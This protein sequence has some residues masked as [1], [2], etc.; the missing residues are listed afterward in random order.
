M[1]FGKHFVKYYFKY[2]IFFALGIGVLI[3]IDYVQLDIPRLLG[4]IINKLEIYSKF[5]NESM[6]DAT[7]NAITILVSNI[8]TIVVI[9]TVGRML[10]RLLI[11]GT[12]RRIEYDLRNVMF[13][14]ATNLSQDFYSHEKVGGMM[15]YFINDLAAIRMAFGP[16]ILTL[17]D[18][19]FLGGFAVYRMLGLNKTMTI[20][21]IV[22]M[23]FMIVAMYFI[24]TSMRKQFRIRQEKFR[25]LSDYTQ[26]NFSGISVIKAYVKEIVSLA[27]FRRKS[28]ELYEFNIKYVKRAA[29]SEI[30]TSIAIN[31]VIITIIAYGG[32]LVIHGGFSTG[33]LIEYVG[34]FTSLLWPTR[35]LARFLTISSQAQASS[36]RVAEF[37]DSEVLVKDSDDL[38]EV[39]EIEPSITFKNLNFA[40]PDDNT[41]VLENLNF[42]IK[43]GEMVGILGRTGSGK[44]TIVDLLLRVYNV[45]ENQILIGGHDIMK[46]P[47]KQV[48]NTIGY[49]PQDN[50]LF[51]DTITNNIGFAYDNVSGEKIVEAAKLSDIYSN[52]LEF[53][54]GFDTVLGERGVTVSGGQKQRIS[55]ARA[56]AKN[57]DILIL[58]DSVS[59]VDTKTEETIIS[60]LYKIREGKTTIFIAHRISTV[61]NMDKIILVEEGKIVDVGNHEELLERSEL[62]QDMVRRQALE[63]EVM[64]DGG[65]INEL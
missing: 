9:V 57:P 54:E 36:K 14:H 47:L 34:Y 17:V 6:G 41:S 23:S 15:T 3:Y 25:D 31:A 37:L 49:V 55:I 11:F 10:W 26:E 46:L 4:E 21:A 20:I 35:A 39:N 63:E 56:I 52:I 16:G 45:D 59:A 30:A 29:W 12:S 53:K 33:Q 28:D 50:F 61:R 18:G 60:N 38:I 8:L 58:D 7:M 44:T 51:S 62:Y 65:D 24:N 40:Y 19:I 13:T 32:V 22:P 43:A 2:F 48:R 1:V 5:P 42:E 64:T 27:S